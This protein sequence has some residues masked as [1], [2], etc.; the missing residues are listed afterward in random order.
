MCHSI[1]C[2]HVHSIGIQ[3]A[4]CTVDLLVKQFDNFGR[5]AV[6]H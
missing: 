5:A 2:M 6:T 1:A 4:I 3:N